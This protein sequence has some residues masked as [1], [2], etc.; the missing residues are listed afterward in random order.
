MNED[1][2]QIRKGIICIFLLCCLTACAKDKQSVP[3]IPKE[4][5]LRTDKNK[6]TV[7][8][9]DTQSDNATASKIEIAQGQ[10]IGYTFA[11]S[12]KGD[13]FTVN[14]EGV[15]IKITPSGECSEIYNAAGN[16]TALCWYTGGIIAYDMEK[17]MLLRIDE[18]NGEP[19]VL[20]E[21][22]F[23]Y[24]LL[25][26]RVLGEELY[27]LMVPVDFEGHSEE[28]SYLNLGERMYRFSLADGKKEYL[29]EL[30]NV[31]AFSTAEGKRLIY[32]AYQNG[33]Y[34]LCEYEPATG[35]QEV[36]FD[37]MK[38]FGTLYL[39]AMLYENGV[40]VYAELDSPAIRFLDLNRGK[41]LLEVEN[42]LVLRGLDFISHNG[43]IF[44]RG[45]QENGESELTWE[46]LPDLL[47]RSE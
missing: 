33:T 31:L 47:G 11:I 17:G 27:V 39:S 38:Q 42:R 26:M 4:S 37:M 34:V 2:G 24:D 5:D 10:E 45:Y 13:F 25:D 6:V 41:E 19:S 18:E 21:S 29:E 23:V 12:D 35:R 43:N 30:K 9:D 46:Y 7:A 32:Y 44:C 16:I 40:F 1:M 20:A 3:N 28:N 15:L 8:V 36:L 14:D 22:F